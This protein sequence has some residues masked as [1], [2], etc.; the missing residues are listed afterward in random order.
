LVA[1]Q[2]R[3]ES[4]LLYHPPRQVGAELLWHVSPFRLVA[5]QPRQES[6]LLYQ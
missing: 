4:G 6:E 2:P 1:D 5:D 3:Q